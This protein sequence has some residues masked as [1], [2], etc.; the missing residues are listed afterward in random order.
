MNAEFDQGQ[1]FSV[2]LEETELDTTIEQ[3]TDIDVDVDLDGAEFMLVELTQGDEFLCE[4]S[5]G[6][7]SGDYEGPYEVT[8]TASEQTLATENKTMEANVTVHATP[9]SE[10]SNIYGGETVTIL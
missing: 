2:E 7:S 6:V 4:F 3:E 5:T 10:V 8:P 9:Y 1:S